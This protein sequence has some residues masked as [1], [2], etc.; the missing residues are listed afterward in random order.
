MITDYENVYIN[1]SG[2]QVDP[3]IIAFDMDSVLNTG[4]SRAIRDVFCRTYGITDRDI[5]DTDPDHGHR[6]FNMT[7][8][9]VDRNHIYPMITEAIVNDSPSF[10]PTPYMQKVLRHVHEVTGCPIQVVTYRDK[11]T[12]HVTHDWLK[13]NLDDIPFRCY[14]MSGVPKKETLAYM[15]ADIFIDDR[16]KTI[17]D[18]LGEIDYP[19]MY[20]RPWNQ[21]RPVR[22][23]ALQINDLRD[24]IPLLNIKLG[25]VPTEWPSY[26]PFPQREE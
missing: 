10:L 15:R 1:P 19:V 5:M 12:V 4:C 21:G 22:L 8:A 6:I 14:I 16:H 20:K 7:P 24:I 25:R 13:E 26:I 23:P 17:L 9:G 18:L 2:G 3:S 11:S